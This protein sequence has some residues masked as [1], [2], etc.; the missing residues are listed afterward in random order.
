MIYIFGA[1][2]DPPHAGHGAITRALLHYRNPEKIVLIPSGRRN[3]KEY[4]VSNEHRKELC[5]I[6]VE[7]IRDARVIADYY[8]LDTFTG[9]MITQD[10]DIYAREKYGEDIIHIFGTDTI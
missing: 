6:F 1:A 2:F 4:K 8:F 9:E 3:D 7:E 10:V 5:Q